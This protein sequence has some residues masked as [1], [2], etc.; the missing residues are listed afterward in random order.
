M[1]VYYGP[2]GHTERN[3][4][5]EFVKE[6]LRKEPSYWAKGSGDS[7]LQFENHNEMLIFFKDKV[8]GV[9]IMQHPDY[10]APYNPDVDVETIYH[11]VGGEPMP[12]PSCCYVSLNTAEEI[13]SAYLSNRL[14]IE[15]WKDIYEIIDYKE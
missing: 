6:I 14:V 15:D 9:F 11:R 1:L 4:S 2:D 5:F 13:L 10:L 7:S 8:D 3:P 12:I